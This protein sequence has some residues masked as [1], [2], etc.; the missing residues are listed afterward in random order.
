MPKIASY[1]RCTD[2]SSA[3]TS[4]AVANPLTLLRRMILC[5]LDMSPQNYHTIV[6]SKMLRYCIVFL[7]HGI[8]PYDAIILL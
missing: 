8:L 4:V 7:N 6:Y 2:S 5:V 1:C 3:A